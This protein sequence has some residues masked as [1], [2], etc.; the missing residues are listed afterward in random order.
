MQT[1]MLVDDPDL[2]LIN[3]PATFWRGTAGN[4]RE[5]WDAREL[6]RAFTSRELRSR[7]KGSTLGWAWALVKPLVM[8][9]VYGLAVGVFLGAGRETPQ[10]MIFI[11]CGLLAWTLFSTIVTGAI[12]SVVANGALLSRASFP[13]LLLP[14]ST[15]AAAL[16]DFALQASVLL[17]AYALFQDLPEPSALLWLPPALLLLVV[18]ALAIGLFFAAVN[19]YVRDVGFLVDVSLTV[20]FW[21]T[22][23]LYSYG[24]VV[25]GAQDFGVAG[26]IATRIYML[27]P[28]ANAVFGFHNALWPAVDSPAALAFAFPGRLDVR[29]AVMT[30]ICV[31]LLWL[32]MRVFVRLSAN[33]GQEV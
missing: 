14:L 32:S 31:V 16:V 22:P 11:Y 13:R 21:L 2:R 19:V 1:P 10:F 27:N 17:V 23:V 8:L 4:L 20:G 24:Q 25:R 12:G 28:M 6:L 18:F 26:D 5:V 3:A 9:L 7:Y 15:L 30:A 33:F 29:I